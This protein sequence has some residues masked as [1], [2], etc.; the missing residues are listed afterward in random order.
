MEIKV[1]IDMAP[2]KTKK[3]CGN[4]KYWIQWGVSTGVCTNRKTCCPDKMNYQTC[5]KFESN[6]TPN[7]PN[8]PQDIR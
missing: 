5:K 2:A 7:N 3:V 8:G 4:C 1:F 6:E